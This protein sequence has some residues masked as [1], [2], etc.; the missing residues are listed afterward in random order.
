MEGYRGRGDVRR[1]IWEVQGRSRIKDRKKGKASAKEQGG[2]GKT[3]GDIGGL[4]EGI[5]MKTYMHGPMDFV[6]TLQLRFRVGDLGP[7]ERRKR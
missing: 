1:E 3:L 5:G 6:K 2:I 7:P 4:R